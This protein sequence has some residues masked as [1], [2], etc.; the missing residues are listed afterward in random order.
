VWI[1][2]LF[3]SFVFIA[4]SAG[5]ASNIGIPALPL[6]ATLHLSFL[7]DFLVLRYFVRIIGGSEKSIFTSAL[8]AL[9]TL[10]V[11]LSE[12]IL[13]SAVYALIVGVQLLRLRQMGEIDVPNSGRVSLAHVLL[14][15][16]FLVL[17]IGVVWMT[18]W[19]RTAT[20]Q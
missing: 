11:F 14:T 3:T 20:P 5:F 18:S 6:R 13:V 15:V 16:V 19:W 7:L 12:P 17:N 9:P 2:W 1:A 4:S 10:T 8:T